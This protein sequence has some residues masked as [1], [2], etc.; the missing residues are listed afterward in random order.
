[1]QSQCTTI[2][3]KVDRADINYIRTTL[4]SYDGMAVVRTIDP[5]EA[6]IELH[7]A[8]GCEQMILSL[9]DSLKNEGLSILLTN[10]AKY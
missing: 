3:A 5:I 9:L 4:E 10:M 1:M 8:P 7:I 6:L 2:M